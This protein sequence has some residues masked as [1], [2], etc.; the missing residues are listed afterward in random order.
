MVAQPRSLSTALVWLTLLTLAACG[1]AD[2]GVTYAEDIR[3][4]FEDR[5]IFCHQPGAPFGP[6]TGSGIDIANPFAE[7]DGLVNAPNLW[8]PGHPELPEKTV[9]PGDP[10]ASFLIHKIAAPELGY[11]PESGIAGAFM[12]FQSTAMTLEE[13]GL[14]EQWVSDGAQDDSFF[15]CQ[16]WYPM[17]PTRELAAECGI[18]YR[19]G[20]PGKCDAC[21]FAG[22]HNPPDLADPFG[23][24]GI[25]S[26]RGAYR[27]DLLRV[28]PGSPERSLL[29]QKLRASAE[30]NLP[31]SEY[32]TPMPKPI[33]PLDAE[34]V[35]LVRQ[36][37]VEG[38]KP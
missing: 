15:R 36:W 34:Q 10:E 38:A 21:H 27:A 31:S 26:V 2:D 17:M 35:A 6:G 8:A 1:E 14:V 3:P 37:I 29:V 24:L 28:E 12:P 32:G 25:V 16:V 13:V 18:R 23:P 7:E 19:I 22:T 33:L 20:A 30:G 9:V 4:L 5:C 11:L